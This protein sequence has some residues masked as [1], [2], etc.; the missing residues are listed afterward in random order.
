M[1]LKNV[2]VEAV[3]NSKV[4]PKEVRASAESACTVRKSQFDESYIEFLDT[5]I[6]LSPRGPE[7][8]ARLRKRRR[9]LRPFCGVPLIYGVIPL[10]DR[11]FSI[12]VLPEKKK[13]VHSEEYDYPYPP[14]VDSDKCDNEAV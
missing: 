5:Q 4:L 2:F 1:K 11:H 6:R 8:T 9:A 3:Q 13:V 12:Y 7:W 10:E 14:K